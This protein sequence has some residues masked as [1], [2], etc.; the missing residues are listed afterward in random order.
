VAKNANLYIRVEQGIKSKAE[1]L[2]SNFGI[3]VT[4]AVNMFL[5]KAIMVGGLPFD[6]LLPKPNEETLAAMMEVQEM[7][8]DPMIGKS[9][10]D[11]D[12]M[13]KELLS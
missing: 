4:D 7:K 5:H 6:V 12:E 1:S 3:T 11:I 8:K 2:F 13:M 10:D 9:Y